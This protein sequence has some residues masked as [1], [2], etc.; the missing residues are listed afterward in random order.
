VLE[1]LDE[2]LKTDPEIDFITF[3]GAGEPTL[4]SG[5]GKVVDFVKDNYPQYKICLLTNATLL[6][7]ADVLKEIS[8]IDLAVPSLD[9]SNQE[10]FDKINRPVPGVGFDSYISS[11]IAYCNNTRSEIWLELFIVPG[12]NDSDESI[13]RFTDIVKQIKPAKVQLN[14]LDRPGCVDWIKPSA[15]ENTMRFVKA[16]EPFVPVEA[17]GPFKYKSAALQKAVELGELDQAIIELISR[18]PSTL[19][20]MIEAFGAEESAIKE[21][22]GLLLNAGKI[23]SERRD[24]GEFFSVP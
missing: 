17:V 7:N 21:R 11:L 2:F 13:A 20:D 16:L 3:S 1:Q 15:P 5:I 18:R 10:E 6:G 19:Q 12:V 23:Q 8:R 24:R 14:T 9:A 22:L 4:N